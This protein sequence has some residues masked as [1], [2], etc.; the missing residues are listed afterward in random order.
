[1]VG[2][3]APRWLYALT[4]TGA[5]SS[6]AAAEA[7]LLATDAN[8]TEARLMGEA[9]PEGVAVVLGEGLWEMMMAS[10]SGSESIVTLCG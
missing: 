5:G 8:E 6:G 3:S 4:P 2:A 9:V 7:T 1:M 10:E